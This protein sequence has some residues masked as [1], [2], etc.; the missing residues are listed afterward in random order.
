M[1]NSTKH[2]S[3]LA[4]TYA[5]TLLELAWEQNFAVDIGKEIE[6]LGQIL[7]AEPNFRLYLADPAIGAE[8]RTAA[9]DRI[10]R[11]RVSTLVFNFIGVLNVHGRL[12]LLSEIV[13]AYSELLDEKL[14]NVDVEVTSAQ[15]L[16]GEE[17]EQ[18]RTRINT[19]LSKNS[20]IRQRV[21]ESIIGGL[22]IRVGDRVIDSSVKQQLESIR[23]QLHLASIK[24]RG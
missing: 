6:G 9:L 17:I 7:K 11:G 16:S 15:R 2:H 21:D 14:G 5:Q 12:G 23:K 18:V 20:I 4:V 10:F 19:A 24:V 8:E 1:A 22:I 3:P 13:P